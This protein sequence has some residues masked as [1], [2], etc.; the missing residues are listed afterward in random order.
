MF[1][2]FNKDKIEKENEDLK[3]LQELIKE[4]KDLKNQKKEMN[5][6]TVPLYRNYNDT[7]NYTYSVE[8]KVKSLAFSLSC[9]LECKVPMKNFIY[10]VK[11]IL[12]EKDTQ[13]LIDFGNRLI[14]SANYLEK[15]KKLDS[16][17][18]QIENKIQNLKK[19]INI[20]Y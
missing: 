16:Q 12:P 13:F 6:I 11:D 1:N 8:K 10:E 20:D 19:K 7:C 9:C 18:W 3:K 2:L 15:E 14:E 17:I 4:L 5:E